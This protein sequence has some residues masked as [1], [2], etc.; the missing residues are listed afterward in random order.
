MD[1]TTIPWATF[2]D[3]EVAG[4]GIT[5]ERARA[6]ELPC[7]AFRLGFDQVDRAVID[8]CTAG[9]AKVVASPAGK[10]LGATVAGPE[11]SMLIHEIAL[12]MASGVP[13]HNLA[14]AVPIYPS[15]G[16]V[17]HQLAVQARRE[18]GEGLHSNG[19]QDLLRVHSAGERR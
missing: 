10:I 11:S 5:E 14:A 12:A 15:Y 4:V 17:L 16:S 3:P 19:A 9:F 1:Y 8:G 6:D 18:A 2:T 7:R 13:L